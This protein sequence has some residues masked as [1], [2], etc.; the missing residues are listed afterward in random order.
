MSIK[1]RFL[2]PLSLAALVL[3]SFVTGPAFYHVDPLKSSLVWSAKKVTG[4]HTGNINLSSG[5]LQVENNILKGGSFEI[6][7]RT[8][9]ST[10]IKD[11]S[12]NQKFIRHMK[13]DDFFS[14]EKYPSA[15]LE[16]V[17][18]TPKGDNNY[19]VVANLTIKGI[20]QPVKFPA[21]VAVDNDHITANAKITVDRTKYD[22]R[23]RS[24]S[25][26]ENLGDKM[27]Y[28]DFDLNVS[29]VATKK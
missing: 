29:L 3:F 24:K 16:I 12:G 19:D 27:I 4:G 20:T 11:Q 1:K 25:F 5:S 22:I 26:F 28:D 6:D 2:L 23:F 18:A 8:I 9:T 10:D 7:T 17:S 14:V 21:T 15:K 13:S